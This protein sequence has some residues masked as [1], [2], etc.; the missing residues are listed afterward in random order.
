MRFNILY[1]KYIWLAVIFV[2]A[3]SAWMMMNQPTEAQGIGNLL[4]GGPK[5]TEIQENDVVLGNP[6]APVTIIE[7][8]SLTCPHCAHFHKDVFPELQK[9]YI[10]PGKVRFVLRPYPL[11]EPALKAAMLTICAG[12]ERYYTFN[13]VL[14]ETQDRWAFGTDYMDALAKVAAVG[15]IGQPQFEKCMA[16]TELERTILLGSKEAAEQLAVKS[17]PSFFINGKK[18]EGGFALNLFTAAIDPLLSK[19]EPT[20]PTPKE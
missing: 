19:A 7:Y 20:V 4:A 5:L 15:G 14:F 9:Q 12:K 2:G 16:D 10:E 18:L 13:K 8:A 1:N 6:E 11:N 3:A 17:T